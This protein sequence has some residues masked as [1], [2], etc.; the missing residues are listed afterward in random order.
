MILVLTPALIK[1]ILM[2]NI[3]ATNSH[4]EVIYLLEQ[5]YEAVFDRMRKVLNAD[6]IGFFANPQRR[7]KE[8]IWYTELAGNFR[9]FELLS[10]E[11][12]GTA[13]DLLAEQQLRLLPKLREDV[14]LAPL[15][16]SLFIVPSESALVAGLMPDNHLRVILT[17]WGCRLAASNR[18]SDP[19]RVVINRPRP[20]R[21][22]VNIMATYSDGSRYYHEEFI[23][24]YKDRVKKL[25]TNKEG[26][27]LLGVFK[28]GSLLTIK[29]TE[30]SSEEILITT[31]PEQEDYVVVFP[32]RIDLTIE[33]IDQEGEK[34]PNGKVVI[35]YAG[36]SASFISDESG[37]IQ[38]LGHRLDGSN[39]E[40]QLE[41]Q[42]DTLSIYTLD[43]NTDRVKYKLFQQKYGKVQVKVIGEDDQPVPSYPIMMELEGEQSEEFRSNIDGLIVWGEDVFEGQKV[44]IVDAKDRFNQKELEVTKGENEVI[45]RVKRPIPPRVSVRLIGRRNKVIAGAGMDF[46]I[47]GKP[48]SRQTNEQGEC[49]FPA[50]LFNNKEKVP[51]L[52]Q[53]T[54]KKAHSKPIKRQFRYKEGTLDYTIKLKKSRWWFWLLPL[55]LL[56]L[57]LPFQKDVSIQT[58]AVS[59]KSP[60]I[61]ANVA[62]TYLKHSIYEG[63]RFWVKDTMIY[64]TISDTSG[65][66]YFTGIPFTLYGYL[67]YHR[68]RILA[69][70][71]ADCLVSESQSYTFHWPTAEFPGE[72]LM[73]PRM[74][75][76]DFL[77]VDREDKQPLPNANYEMKIDYRGEIY[78][79]NG[80][81]GPDGRVLVFDVP[82]C[83]KVEFGIGRADGYYSDSLLNQQL[84][85]ILSRS[86]EQSRVLN[87]QPIKSSISF[88]VQ[89]CSTGQPLP[90]AE[91]QLLIEGQE[92]GQPLYTNIDGLGKGQYDDLHI[93]RKVRIIVKNPPYFNPEEL[94]LGITVDEFKSLPDSAR[95]VCLDP[96]DVGLEFVNV[97]ETTGQPLP[98]V[99]N[100]IEVIRGGK[101]RVDTVVSNR[102]GHFPVAN[103]EIGDRLSIISIKEPNYERNDQT[104]FD[105]TLEDLNE[106]SLLDRTIP[107]RPKIIDVSFRTIDPETNTLVDNATLEV[108]VDGERQSNIVNSG[109][110]VF[111]VKA[112]Y[113]S[114]VS[115]V[116]EKDGY[117][118]NERK[119]RNELFGRLLES[120]Q[121]ERD[122]PLKANQPPMQ[123][124]RV[125][126]SG[127]YVGDISD[128]SYFSKVY[129]V[130]QYS[131][132]VGAGTYANNST[133]FPKA[134]AS[135][136][137]GIAIDEGTRVTI[138]SGQNFTGSVLL[139]IEGP[140]IINNYMYRNES[141][142]RG[143]KTKV[144]GGGLQAKFPSRV[145]Y[146]SNSDM[147]SWSYGSMKVICDE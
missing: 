44:R 68:N 83:G 124:C 30:D 31:I 103:L 33:L 135:T 101:E 34:V 45:L 28:H 52:I 92:D 95:T 141:W 48:Y 65:M 4:S 63:G 64:R 88:F 132:F 62:L 109:N 117:I 115:I 39:L 36:E 25:K 66:A 11:E 113:N 40:I 130:D 6:E 96:V 86:I 119:I 84:Q 49:H 54:G 105:R 18:N 72:L 112:P 56:L 42:P 16:D 82:L 12:K 59:D 106:S 145:R 20:D 125:F 129:Q 144:F 55:L 77:L 41:E 27:A 118:R 131:E 22:K 17:Q 85:D 73:N 61:G 37:E 102:N 50:E 91:A 58:V 14:E 60:V 9:P 93:L 21:D 122:I 13:S 147:H 3:L 10:E 43:K 53:Q 51:V 35:K 100:I 139:D 126:V 123:N 2:A 46:E 140:A 67:F 104:I 127:I 78:E 97:D 57:L 110:G 69:K 24:E 80:K 134:V 133:A 76:V 138:Y 29:S 89:N 71:S 87:L 23:L 47:G 94:D 99:I 32:I 5:S 114:I 7:A 38:L 128:G 75:P 74:V 136:F 70:A 19:L 79:F 107:L 116:A 142:G 8:Q 108:Y 146:Y 81:S 26:V 98:G 1:L 121:P 143:W 120:D 15:V 111:E 137:D 90:G